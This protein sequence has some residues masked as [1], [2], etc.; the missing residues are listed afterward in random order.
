MYV[1]KKFRLYES[2]IF[3]VT[4]TMRKLGHRSYAAHA[5]RI[6]TQIPRRLYFSNC[7]HWAL[8]TLACDGRD[9]SRVHVPPKDWGPPQPPLHRRRAQVCFVLLLPSAHNPHNRS[10]YQSG[11]RYS[12]MGWMGQSNSH[13]VWLWK[14][15]GLFIVRPLPSR[16]YLVSSLHVLSH[17]G[18]HDE[19]QR[20]DDF[21]TVTQ[22]NWPPRSLVYIFTA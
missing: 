15:F 7:G 5:S 21:K 20:Y 8:L 17:T 12:W 10:S 22:L 14:S 18:P 19:R 3:Q 16:R 1:C 4:P 11:K 2:R 13:R 6:V 9:L